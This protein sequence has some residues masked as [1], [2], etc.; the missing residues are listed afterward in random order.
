MRGSP[1]GRR[2]GRVAG[3]RLPDREGRAGGARRRRHERVDDLHRLW[4]RLPLQGRQ[5]RLQGLAGRPG[6]DLRPAVRGRLDFRGDLARAARRRV[7]H[8]P[9]H[10]LR[11]VRRRRARLPGDHSRHQ[12]LRLGGC[13]RRSAGHRAHRGDDA[14]RH[15][16]R[17]RSLHRGRGRCRRRHRQPAAIAADDLGEPARGSE[18][19][20]RRR[21]GARVAP[22]HRSRPVDEDRLRRQPGAGGRHHA[23][24]SAAHEPARREPPR[25]PRLSVRHGVVAPHRRNRI[26]LQS[27]FRHDRRDAARD[28]PRL[29]ARRL[30]GTEL[31]RHRA[32]GRRHRLH[33]VV[34]RRDDL[35]GS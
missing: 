12:V 11:H 7:H 29:P 17:L 23:G 10:R 25:D 28:V 24:A 14:G 20:P 30:D 21:C 26:L 6:K 33:R 18:G 1:E 32:V 16:Q 5:R 3:P 27:H 15:P 31:L 9:L 22:A 13:R 8:R 19:L 4:R 35:P 34:Q 2:L